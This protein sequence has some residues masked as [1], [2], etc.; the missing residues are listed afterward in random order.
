M[1]M[2]KKI[3]KTTTT[4]KHYQLKLNNKTV[5]R[6]TIRICFMA[7]DDDKNNNNNNDSGKSKRRG[8]A[9]KNEI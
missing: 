7:L 1:E 5:V 9:S 3:T 4:T 8:E 6:L 2:E